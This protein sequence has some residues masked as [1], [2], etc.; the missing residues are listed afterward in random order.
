MEN[1]TLAFAKNFGIG[2]AAA[3]LAGVGVS[4]LSD[5]FT[6]NGKIIG[7]FSTISQYVAYFSIFL[8]LH[9]RDNRDV[10]LKENGKFNWKS[11]VGD[12]LKFNAA[13][14]AI[15]V[16]YLFG[17]PFLQ[18]YFIDEGYSA[19]KSSLTADAI[20]VSAYIAAAF[21]VA[22]LTG[23]IRKKKG[24]LEQEILKK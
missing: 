24:K 19:T 5:L 7:A 17:R 1:K 9:A 4:E 18:D 3:V 8:P 16:A 20:G 12:N 6:D 15:D 22:R 21:P 2:A 11:F 14:S 10:Y 23:M 13:L